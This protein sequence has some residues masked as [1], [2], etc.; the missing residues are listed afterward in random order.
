MGSNQTPL[1]MNVVYIINIATDRK[2]GRTVPYKFGIESWKHYCNKHNAKLV[3][4]EEPILPYDDLR[5]N[6]HK[7]FIVKM[8]QESLPRKIDVILIASWIFKFPL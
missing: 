7:V 1:R 4:L 6:W 5:P 2:P 8:E 3:V